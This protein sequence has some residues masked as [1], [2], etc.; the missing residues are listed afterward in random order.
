MMKIVFVTLAILSFTLAGC[1]NTEK[2]QAQVEYPERKHNEEE[3]LLVLTKH[4]LE[5]IE[6]AVEKAEEKTVTVP[7]ALPGR[8]ALNDRTTAHITA[9]VVGRIEKVHKVI[10]DRV[11]QGEVVVEL[12]SQ[13][14]LTMQS[15]FVQAEERFKRMTP[16]QTSANG[17]DYGTA[18]AI[19]ES[20]KRKLQIV[21]LT[22][23]EIS[24]LADAHIPLTYLPVRTPFSGTLIAGEVRQGEVVQV[25][26]DFFTIANLSE[27]WVIADV[28]EHDLPLVQEGM[29]GDVVVASYPAE[30]FPG[31]LTTIY[32]IV[33]EKSRTIKTR[34][35][36]ENRRGKLKPEMFATVHVNAQFGGRSLKVPSLAV[37]E[38]KNERY[39]F[40][41][42]N[43][44]SFES[45]PVT[46]GFETQIYTEILDGLK[47][48]ERV[49]TKGT[50]YLKSE[51]AKE[52]FEEED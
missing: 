17:G 39:V 23:K 50:F 11:Q 27:L 19:Y 33:D 40:V 6:F 51:R 46:I 28:F 7:L 18:H 1:G 32:D 52:T 2:E 25:G 48:G 35:D 44:T 20:A 47:P 8:V 29:R 45:R 4:Q 49:V 12:Y 10:N 38:N 3:A 5:H 14:F 9:R 24:D 42:V 37:M 30:K 16:E 26:T 22:D 34:F 41:A 15:E 31:R 13:E 36:V 21:G 43:D